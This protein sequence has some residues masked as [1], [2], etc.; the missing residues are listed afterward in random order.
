MSFG[1][2]PN[3]APPFRTGLVGC[4]YW[5]SKLL[6][7][8][9]ASPDFVPS[10][11]YFPSLSQL[12]PDQR[13]ALPGLE[14]SPDLG[15]LLGDPGL[16]VVVF[17]TPIAC[18]GEGVHAAL[19]AGR[20]VLVEK[21]LCLDPSEA[22]ALQQL[23]E[24]RGLVLQTEYTYT[25]SP[26]LAEAR[27]LV[28]KEWIGPLR[29]V[30]VRL[31]QLGRF[32]DDDVYPLLVCH[33]LS[34]VGMFVDLSAVAWTNVPGVARGEGATTALLTGYTD[35]GVTVLVDASLDDPLRDKAVLLFG[36]EG[37]VSYRPLSD[38]PTLL[39]VRY[40]R[41]P[42]TDDQSVVSV[43]HDQDFDENDNLGRALRSFAAVLRG[44]ESSNLAQSVQ[45]T[46]TLARFR[47]SSGAADS[48]SG[49]E[50]VG[51]S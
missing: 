13:P 26:G 5:G 30:Q 14:P 42:A 50:A 31:H 44:E 46:E 39:A 19:Q 41:K 12:P 36:E 8:L 43:R 27:A 7:A 21:P 28:M 35:E 25:F 33:A 9:D 34:I 49:P 11:L 22:R 45:I 17:A 10:R 3:V 16:D 6:A 24:E 37:T 2:S 47:G 38:G 48:S 40:D 1:A 15:A 20:H 4:G 18:H 29:H 32:R 23:A 51:V